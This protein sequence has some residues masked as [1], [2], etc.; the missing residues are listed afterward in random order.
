M[1]A[2]VVIASLALAGVALTALGAI[3]GSI[4][5]ARA[6][7][8][9]AGIAATAASEAAKKT[10]EESLIDQLQEELTRYR[11]Q[12]DSRLE[13]LE[14]ENQ[15]YRDFIFVQRDHMVEHGVKPPPWPDTLP[16]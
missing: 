9:V 5:A 2:E 15:A 7:R 4:I 6:Q 11:K 10:A 3:I 13:R 1:N 12:T 8:R 16:R 14:R